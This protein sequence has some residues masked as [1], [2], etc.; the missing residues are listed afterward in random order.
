MMT[1]AAS[2]LMSMVVG[3]LKSAL[4]VPPSTSRGTSSAL[5]VLSCSTSDCPLAVSPGP[6]MTMVAVV[7]ISSVMP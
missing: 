1:A 7:S 6:L 4:R 3:E 5:S 2:P